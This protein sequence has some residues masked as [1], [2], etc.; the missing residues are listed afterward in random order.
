[1]KSRPF[2]EAWSPAIKSELGRIPGV[3]ADS[4]D[5]VAGAFDQFRD[6]FLEGS[7]RLHGVDAKA[8]NEIWEMINTMGSW[9]FNLSHSYSYAVVSYWTAWL[10]AHHLLEFAA[11]TLRNA[12]SDESIIRFLR[13]LIREGVPYVSF[14]PELSEMNWS[15][16]EGKLVGGFMGLK[17]IGTSKAQKLVTL[18]A[19]NFGRLP[20]KDRGG[21]LES[22][23][24]S[25]KTQGSSNR[26]AR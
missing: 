7:E 1:M 18:R 13:E 19:Q 10:K 11:A 16:K 22:E 25:E 20:Q 3:R 4:F 17:G 23:R 5:R 8:G 2:A 15:V 14:D 21:D 12:S 24:R 6:K 9:A 26:K